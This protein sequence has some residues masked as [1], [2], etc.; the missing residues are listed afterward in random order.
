MRGRKPIPSHLRVLN[1]TLDKMPEDI[2]VP[3]GELLYAPE[4]M[5]DEQKHSWNYAIENAPDGLL[6]LLDKSVLC[7]WVIAEDLHRQAVQEVNKRGLIVKSPVKGEPM[8]N[9]WLAI[10]NRQAVLMMKAASEMGFSPT[11]RN[12]VSIKNE[13]SNDANPFAEFARG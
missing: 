5:S 7:T 3:Q 9:P 13:N 4:W 2:P 11:S 6:K 10:V 8:Q 12:R 1:G